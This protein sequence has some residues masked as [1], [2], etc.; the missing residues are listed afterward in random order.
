[1]YLDVK[2]VSSSLIIK[3]YLITFDYETWKGHK[4]KSDQRLVKHL[5]VELAKKR[6]KEWGKTVRTMSN[7]TILDIKEIKEDEQKI[8][9]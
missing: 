7:V 4:R 9:L 8:E 2:K 5:N 3:T 6:F 1:M